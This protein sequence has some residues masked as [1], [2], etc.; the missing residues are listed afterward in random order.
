MS[1]ASL[2]KLSSNVAF[3]RMFSC[4]SLKAVKSCGSNCPPFCCES[5]SKLVIFESNAPNAVIKLVF[6]CVAS[7]ALD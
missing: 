1:K 4:G 7:S 3:A 5:Q 2:K 6:C